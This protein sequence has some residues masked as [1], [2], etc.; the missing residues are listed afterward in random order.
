[1]LKLAPA[2]RST[3][4]KDC[5][6]L[7]SVYGWSKEVNMEFNSKKFEWVRYTVYKDTAPT[8]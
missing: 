1:M 7:Q 4:T 5:E 6:D 8:F 3:S 2:L